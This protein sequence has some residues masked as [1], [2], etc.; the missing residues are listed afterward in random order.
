[1]D[2]NGALTNSWLVRPAPK[3]EP[4]LRLFCLP[5][6]GAGPSAF[7]G[8]AQNVPADV[9]ALYVHLPGRES[10][11][12]EPIIPDVF[13]LAQEIAHARSRRSRNN[14]SHCSAT[15]SER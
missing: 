8:W 12:R 1:M 9:E 6:A 4:A 11:L 2:A 15:A 3:R 13:R 14:H 10:R 5:Y 7:R